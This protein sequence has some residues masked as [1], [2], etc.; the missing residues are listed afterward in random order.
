MI[1]CRV[2]VVHDPGRRVRAVVWVCGEGQTDTQTDTQICMT[3]YIS[4]C[5]RLAQNIIIMI[6]STF[7]KSSDTGTL[8]WTRK[9]VHL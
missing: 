3:I 5:L 2:R 8:I 1:V 6:M 4:R 9:Q 7:L